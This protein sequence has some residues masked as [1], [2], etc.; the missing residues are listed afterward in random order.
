ME[1]CFLEAN[2]LLLDKKNPIKRDFP[3]AI[4][5]PGSFLEFSLPWKREFSLVVKFGI[6]LGYDCSEQGIQNS[7]LRIANKKEM[8]T[9]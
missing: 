3:F 6:F 5:G 4:A 1:I 7:L 2:L 8:K 9:K